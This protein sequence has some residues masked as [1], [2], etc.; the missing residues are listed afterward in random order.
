VSWVPS[1]W[2]QGRHERVELGFGIGV[3]ERYRCWLL[4]P[5]MYVCGGELVVLK[6]SSCS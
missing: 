3:G 5:F 2:G 1:W 6:A 4:E